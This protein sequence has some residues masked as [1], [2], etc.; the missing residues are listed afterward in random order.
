MCGIFGTNNTA[1]FEILYDVN[2]DR[3]NFSTGIVSLLNDDSQFIVK[4][5]GLLDLDKSIGV[6]SESKYTIGHLQ[7]PTSAQRKWSQDTTHPFESLSWLVVHNGVLTNWEKLN[8]AHT[9]W[10]VNPVDTSVIVSMLQQ[11]TEDNEEGLEAPQIIKKVLELVE[12][13][14]AVCIVDADC[15]DVYIARQGSILHYNEVGDFSTLPGK[16]Y[17]VLPEGQILMLRDYNSWIPVETFK[18]KSP[19]LFL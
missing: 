9:K 10:N 5:Q 14:F 15:N 3:G 1:K 19:F 12:G 18:T 4:E 6:H 2:S 17:K 11:F 8:E 13:T 7:A 16:D